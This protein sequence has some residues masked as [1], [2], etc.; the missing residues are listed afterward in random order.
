MRKAARSRRVDTRIRWTPSSSSPTRATGSAARRASKLA[1]KTR[2][3][4]SANGMSARSRARRVSRR[5]GMRPEAR[6]ARS[7]LLGAEYSRPSR[8]TR[9]S[10]SGA[11]ASDPPLRASI[12]TSTNEPTAPRLASTRT[13]SM[14]SSAVAPESRCRSV[15][16]TRRFSRRATSTSGRVSATGS[17][18]SRRRLGSSYAWTGSAAPGATGS[19]ISSR[20]NASPSNDALPLKQSFSA[21]APPRTRSA[22]PRRSRS[23]AAVSR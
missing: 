16:R 3:A 10:A 4:A 19:S 20:R 21:A 9:A 13:R 12:S 2:A 14:Q 22:P 8:C 5:G 7:S 17:T 23:S 18:K 15:C 11:K 6:S 1:R